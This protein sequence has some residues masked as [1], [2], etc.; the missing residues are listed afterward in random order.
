[1]ISRKKIYMAGVGGMLFRDFDAYAAD[2]ERPIARLPVPGRT[3]T[4][5]CETHIDTS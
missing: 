2:V 4:S 3:P 1:M 5:N